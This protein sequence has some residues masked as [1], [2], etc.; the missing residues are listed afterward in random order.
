MRKTENSHCFKPA[1][2]K[3]LT[4][5]LRYQMVLELYVSHLLLVAGYLFTYW[6]TKV[7]EERK[8]VIERVNEQLQGGGG[9]PLLAYS[10]PQSHLLCAHQQ[11][12]RPRRG[13]AV[14]APLCRTIRALQ[15]RSYR[16]GTTSQF[17]AH[18]Y[19][20][21]VLVRSSY[22]ESLL[23]WALDWM[24]CRTVVCFYLM[25]PVYPC[26]EPLMGHANFSIQNLQQNFPASRASH[27]V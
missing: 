13:I 12:N 2:K 26:D 21:T 10:Q 24:A 8:A 18:T 5:P 22:G 3:E 9:G 19:A 27:H 4:K 14:H 15:P 20:A 1:K 7:A 23:C 16:C 17:G 25:M 6:H 11:H